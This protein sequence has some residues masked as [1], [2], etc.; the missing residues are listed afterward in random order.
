MEGAMSITKLTLSVDAN[1][2]DKA[3]RISVKQHTNV[4]AMFSRFVMAMD[5]NNGSSLPANSLTR[6]IRMRAIRKNV[7]LSKDW[8]YKKELSDILLDKNGIK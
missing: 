4:S 1:I 5:E 6:K 8:D 3:K 7:N 2:R